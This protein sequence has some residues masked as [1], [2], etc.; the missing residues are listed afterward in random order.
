MAPSPSP[1]SARLALA[2]SCMGH[3]YSHLF[4][5]IFF[6]VA[7]SLEA[8]LGLTHGEVVALIVVGNVL[9]GV[10]APL[11]GWLG[12]RWSASAMVG[13]F[14]VG[15]GGGMILTGL[16]STPFAIGV[17]LAVTGLFASIYHPVGIAWLVR[18]AAERGTALGINGVFGGLGP[19]VA[20]LSAGVLI[21]LAGWSAAFLVPGAVVLATGLVFYALLARGV[22]V[23]TKEDRV[24]DPP[25]SRSDTMR[26]VSVLAVTLLCTGLI[27]QA[28]QA[29]LPKLFTERVGDLLGDGSI[30]VSAMVAAVYLAAGA[31]QIIAGWLADRF[32]LKAVYAVAFVLQ[33]PLLAVAAG[34]SG[35][36]LVG[37]AML[38]VVMNVGALPPENALVARYAPSHR[39]GLAFGLK[40]I[41]AF[42]L[43][44]LGVKLEGLLYDLT[45][46]FAWL[47]TILAAVAAVAVAAALLLPSEQRRGSAT[48]EAE[49]AAT[50]AG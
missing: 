4:A 35:A 22:I 6:V 8:E 48:A 43:S 31:A 1:L 17:S 21:D 41:L 9:F 36:T 3:A 10:A 49:P 47:F 37:V 50:G 30:G 27:Y 44:G 20:A 24:S 13:V 42:G 25:A 46:G 34:V 19:V 16:S 18:N 2:F 33:V 26:A 15:T 32:P 29:S 38:M 12:D 5:P 45:G 11:A 28:T 14:F 23:E 39:R 40:F 7:L